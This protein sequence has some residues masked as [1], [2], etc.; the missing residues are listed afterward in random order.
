M[1]ATLLRIFIRFARRATHLKPRC[2]LCLRDATIF[3]ATGPSKVEQVPQ[4]Q[5][6]FCCPPIRVP[7]NLQVL[8][9][10]TPTIPGPLQLLT[11][12]QRP[13]TS[14]PFFISPTDCKSN[15]NAKNLFAP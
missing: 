15:G 2:P 14:L 12:R 13:E 11:R 6:P 4:L 1:V 5:I 7:H 3:S 10:A 8:S 9:N